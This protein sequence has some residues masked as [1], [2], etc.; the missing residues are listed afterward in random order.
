[1]PPTGSTEKKPAGAWSRK[2]IACCNSRNVFSCRSRER[3][4]QENTFL[5]LQHAIDFL[6]H[7][8]A[9]FFSVDPVGGIVYL[10]ATLAGWLGYDLAEVSPTGLKL[11]DLIPGAGAALL[12]NLAPVPGEVKTE[13]L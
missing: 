5:E 6:D 7:A 10:N 11:S 4:R 12:S 13:I 3:E 1:M 9:G 8:P 2:S